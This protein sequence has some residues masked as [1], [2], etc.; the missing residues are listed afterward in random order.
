M[1]VENFHR[2]L[3]LVLKHEGGWANHPLDPGGATMKDVTQR[4][5]SDW[6][7]AQGKPDQSVRDISDAE[8]KVIYRANYWNVV[9]GDDLPSGLDYPTFDSG[10]DSGRFRGAK[11]LQGA[12]GVTADGIV[13]VATLQAAKSAKDKA[14][15]ARKACELR[16]SFLRAS[17]PSRPSARAG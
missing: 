13:G 14:A 2:A 9:R 4:V 17:R 7:R 12:L 6:R 16:R 1:A 10:V 3:S 11:W 5:Y 8:L 15:V